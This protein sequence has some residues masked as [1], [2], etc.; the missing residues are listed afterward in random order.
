MCIAVGFWRLS[1]G[2]TPSVSM[3]I[4]CMMNGYTTYYT[5]YIFR[6]RQFDPAI[7]RMA[8]SFYKRYEDKEIILVQRRRGA[9]LYDYMFKYC[10][11]VD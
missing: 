11:Q 7:E 8:K 4:L 3:Y 9:Y 6:D 10:E 5:G 1:I 2:D